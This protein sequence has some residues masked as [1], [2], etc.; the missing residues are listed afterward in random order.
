[1]SSSDR[2]SRNGFVIVA[3]LWM[4]GALATLVSIYS[5][6]VMRTAHS[7]NFHADY[8]QS[9]ALKSAA[10]ELVAYQL[11]SEPPQSRPTHGEFSFRMS[12]ANVTVKFQ[13]EAARVD[14]N[15][16]P[17]ELIAGLFVVLGATS[18]SAAQYAERI[19]RFRTPL[20]NTKEALTGDAAESL[21]G[22]INGPF[23]HIDELALVPG[24]PASI[25][26]RMLPF[27]T[28]FSG[29]PQV[30][31]IEA[32]P[33]VLS[34]IPGMTK[35]RLGAIVAQ[36][37]LAVDNQALQKILGPSDGSGGFEASGAMRTTIK[38]AYDN[39]RR[40]S[41]DAVILPFDEGPEPYGILSWQE[42]VDAAN[43]AGGV[44]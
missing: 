16:A 32:S 21:K 19:V 42:D 33:V 23:A 4:V 11:T 6:Y 29:R 18:D 41:A 36:R 10:I 5:L 3:V 26:E 34:A 30:D 38:I 20:K 25:V 7:F 44:L 8:L 13:T 35:D 31:V 27:V 22:P 2:D 12:K 39:G 15:A 37:N 14:L 9:E 40:S 17:K 43:H 28:V 1:M 24:L